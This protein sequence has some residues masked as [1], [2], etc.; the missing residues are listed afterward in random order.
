M[1]E[2]TLATKVM[3]G[4][5]CVGVLLYLALYFLLGFRNEVA[6][7]VAY[8]YTVDV[9]T[10]ATAIIVREETV[11]PNSGTYV[12]QVLTEGEKTAAKATV[13]LIYDHP[14]TGG[15]DRTAGI[16]PFLRYTGGG[17]LQ[18][19]RAGGRLHCGAALSGSRRRS[20]HPGGFGA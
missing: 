3:I 13:A 5:L 20:F 16:R 9:G 10:D 7:T 19:G 18:A 8:D 6:T 2:S 17:F 1:K 12:D 11:L 15:G 14:D 4:I